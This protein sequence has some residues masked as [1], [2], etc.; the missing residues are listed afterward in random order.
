AG[1]I[2]F[3]T[4]VTYTRRPLFTNQVARDALREAI[5]QTRENYP[6]DVIAWVL[7]P[8]HLHAIWQLPE[9]DAD[10]STRWRLIKARFT[11]TMCRLGALQPASVQSRS[12]QR[13]KEQPVWQRRFWE[14]T[15][16]DEEDL[17]QHILYVHYN[18]VKH[19]LVDDATEW[20]FSTIHRYD[21]QHLRGRLDFNPDEIARMECE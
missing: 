10:Y 20:P 16:R 5:D 17:H 14:H 3:F 7:L 19:Q 9:D 15:I 8:D 18:P 13:H 21:D 11:R 6:F 1:G 12:R 2:Y 4:A